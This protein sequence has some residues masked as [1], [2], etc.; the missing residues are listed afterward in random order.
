M[1]GFEPRISDVRTDN[2]IYCQSHYLPNVI[3]AFLS[4]RHW[5]LREIDCS[6]TR[7]AGLI[8]SISNYVTHLYTIHFGTAWGCQYSDLPYACSAVA[9]Y[10]SLPANFLL[11]VYGFRP[12]MFYSIGCG[13]PKFSYVMNFSFA[14]SLS[15]KKLPNVTQKTNKNRLR[16]GTF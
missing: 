6:L 11:D 2:F 9:V 8:Y 10:S 13:G 12:K 14:S 4:F 3:C 15:C 5:H 7:R 16:F 1:T